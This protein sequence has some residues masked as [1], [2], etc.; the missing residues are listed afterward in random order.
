MTVAVGDTVTASLK[1][2]GI[3]DV[4]ETP[5]TNEMAD[6]ILALNKLLRSEHQDGASQYLIS[7][8]NFTLR[9]GQ[10]SFTV[11]TAKQ[12]YDVQVDACDVRRIDAMDMGQ[13]IRRAVNF[14]PMYDVTRT[15]YPG[16]VTKAH[17][18]R[19]ADNSILVTVWQVPRADTPLLIE[20]GG[21]IP[22]VTKQSDVLPL[23]DDAV[24]A[25]E[26]L[27]GKRLMG[28][29]GR[30]P[31]AVAVQ[32]QR[33]DLLEQQWLSYARGRQWIRLQRE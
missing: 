4:S 2:F 24:D 25:V 18:E 8:V 31:Q 29:Y 16:L 15:T 9:M 5:T 28:G 10:Q 27:L 6:G 32:L 12:T 33:A 26:H 7:R 1:L 13:Y 19:Q 23:P 14:A 21:R 22:A 20:L 17:Q 3:I 11:G 30:N